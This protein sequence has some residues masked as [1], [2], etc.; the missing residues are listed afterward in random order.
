MGEMKRRVEVLKNSPCLCGSSRPAGQCCF[1]TDRW[2]KPATR[3]GLSELPET[4]SV[5]HCYMGELNSCEG[6][7]SREH[8]ISE[9][10]MKLLA[11]EGEFTISGLPWMPKGE[12]K[13]IGLNSFVTKC[14]C[15][16]HNSR[17]HH[18]DDAALEFFSF[19][20]RTMARTSRDE[21]FLMSGHDI[22]RWLLKTLKALAVSGNL[23]RGQEKLSGEFTPHVSVLS[24]LEDINSWPEGSGLYCVM[25]EGD[26][27]ENYNRFQLMPYTNERGE[28]AGLGC[29]II[30][31]T[32]ILLLEPISIAD[33]PQLATAVHRPA[34][35]KIDAPGSFSIMVLSWE[36]GQAHSKAL[37]LRWLRSLT[38]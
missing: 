7:I 9:S 34:E 19:L 20:K 14:L 27:A 21:R 10:I 28:L 31:L 36:D 16:E 25:R 5:A 11:D 18:L 12:F 30:G 13:T 17:I 38:S 8:L 15:R 35:I 26:F 33:N 6:G 22:E 29:S 32:F 37:K 24:M 3:L 1:Q 2:H 4:G 23:G